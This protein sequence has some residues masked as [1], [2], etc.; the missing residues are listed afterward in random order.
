[1][2]LIQTWHCQHW[3][4]VCSDGRVS[5]ELPSG[6]RA[7]VPRESLRKFIVLRASPGLV[8]AGSSSIGKWL[9][10][11]V[12][13]AVRRYVEDFPA[14]SFDQ[15]ARI[16]GPTVFEARTAFRVFTGSPRPTEPVCWSRAVGRSAGKICRLPFARFLR[17]PSASPKFWTGTD[18]NFLNL[19]GFDG[20][21]VRNRVFSSTDRCTESEV[22]SGA[23][24]GGFADPDE[25][26]SIAGRLLDLVGRERTPKRIVESM[27]TL[28]AEMSASYP[29]TIGPP[30]RFHIIT[31]G[32]SL[33]GGILE[34][35]F[36]AALTSRL[37][38]GAPQTGPGA[39]LSDV[40][41][42]HHHP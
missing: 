19:L 3:G 14:A 41:L 38:T 12:C 25:A 39:R 34:E 13:D 11:S 36:R 4:I 23:T 31:K 27:L 33:G 17:A 10:F 40:L 20:R 15:V 6:K 24:I 26:W 30:Y 1:L 5:L 7:A 35:Q 9:D 28:A 22:S 8:L 29:E 21:C 2:S 18:G 16:I 32:A 37:P 42:P